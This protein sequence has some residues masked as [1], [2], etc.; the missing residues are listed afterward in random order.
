[1]SCWTTSGASRLRMKRKLQQGEAPRYGRRRG[2]GFEREALAKASLLQL[3]LHQIEQNQEFSTALIDC[4]QQTRGGS[5]RQVEQQRHQQLRRRSR[6]TSFTSSGVIQVQ[7]QIPSFREKYCHNSDCQRRLQFENSNGMAT[8]ECRR[9]ANKD[10][11][12]FSPLFSQHPCG[13]NFDSYD[14]FNHMSTSSSIG[15]KGVL[16]TDTMKQPNGQIEQSFPPWSSGIIA[17]QPLPV[18]KQASLPTLRPSNEDQDLHAF[19]GLNPVRESNFESHFHENHSNNP[20]WLHHQIQY[21]ATAEANNDGEEIFDEDFLLFK[22]TGN[23]EHNPNRQFPGSVLPR[24]GRHTC[25]PNSSGQKY[26]SMSRPI[27]SDR[28]GTDEIEQSRYQRGQIVRFFDN[29]VEVNPGRIPSLPSSSTSDSWLRTA[30]SN[31]LN[32]EI[33]RQDMGF[34]ESRKVMHRRTNEPLVDVTNLANTTPFLDINRFHNR[35]EAFRKASPLYPNISHIASFKGSET[36][37]STVTGVTSRKEDTG[38]FF[39]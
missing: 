27:V 36:T 13:T 8:T 29:G 32:P 1:M 21:S 33:F 10:E 15:E 19:F 14:E 7:P 17:H 18:R 9:Q 3:P 35:K 25:S 38:I 16:F 11:P 37:D 5:K 23:A 39:G 28:G 20:R 12:L 30:M 26:S 4:K 34:M 2:G 31:N 6:G 22:V 24:E